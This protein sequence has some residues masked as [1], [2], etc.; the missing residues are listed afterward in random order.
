MKI[1]ACDGDT[2]QPVVPIYNDTDLRTATAPEGVY[3]FSNTIGLSRIVAIG[4][5]P[6]TRAV[7]YF[8]GKE[9]IMGRNKAMTSGVYRKLQDAQVIFQIKE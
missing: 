1:I 5:T 9:T 7:I 8:D 4:N 3:C 2:K 6:E